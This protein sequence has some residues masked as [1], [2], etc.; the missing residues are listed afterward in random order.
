M[1]CFINAFVVIWPC[2][3]K[4]FPSDKPSAMVLVFC[5]CQ[6]LMK[7]VDFGDCAVVRLEDLRLLPTRFQQ[8]PCLAVNVK[9]AGMSRYYNVNFFKLL[10]TQTVEFG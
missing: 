3:S 4:V 1:L 5:L 6:V 9:L 7:F 10:V 8:L 2:F